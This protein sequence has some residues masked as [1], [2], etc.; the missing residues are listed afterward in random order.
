MTC[1]AVQTAPKKGTGQTGLELTRISDAIFDGVYYFG[2]K[3]AAGELQSKLKLLKPTCS[4]RK[5]MSA[6]WVK[7]KQQGNPPCGRTGHTMEYL[8]LN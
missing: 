4:E 5:V 8:P 3:N 6:E 7:L 2:G 1:C